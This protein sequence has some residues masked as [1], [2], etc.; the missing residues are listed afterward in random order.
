M[1][2]VLDTATA[3]SGSL[4]HGGRQTLGRAAPMEME[5][6]AGKCPFFCF[7][8]DNDDA[9]NT[10]TDRGDRRPPH[11][12]TITIIIGVAPPMAQT[13]QKSRSEISFWLP[14]A[15]LIPSVSATTRPPQCQE[16]DGTAAATDT[17]VRLF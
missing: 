13:E 9:S 3:A 5:W 2:L 10:R 8:D 14:F 12:D 17:N 15:L 6:E 16:Q 1:K 4:N 7:H 11:N